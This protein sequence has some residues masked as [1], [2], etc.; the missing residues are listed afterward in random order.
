MPEIKIKQASIQGAS[1]TAEGNPDIPIIKLWHKPANEEKPKKL[2]E[3]VFKDIIQESIIADLPFL[4]SMSF[5]K[6]LNSPLGSLE[7]NFTVPAEKFTKKNLQNF[8][9]INDQLILEFGYYGLNT[10]KHKFVITQIPSFSYSSGWFFELSVSA[11]GLSDFTLSQNTKKIEFPKDL[12]EPTLKEAIAHILSQTFEKNKIEIITDNQEDLSKKLETKNYQGVFGGSNPVESV[13][14]ALLNIGYILVSIDIEGD[15]IKVKTLSK[16]AKTGK[17]IRATITGVSYEI[18]IRETNAILPIANLNITE[19][20][21]QL[22][23]LFYTNKFGSG[24][25]EETLTF[26]SAIEIETILYPYINLLDDVKLEEQT[27]GGIYKVTEITHQIIPNPRTTIELA[28][29]KLVK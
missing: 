8:F 18:K 24:I 7:L 21:N 12:K 13:K 2:S 28:L 29:T 26:L 22:W 16:D 5:R 15:T 4:S 20:L 3:T 17:N 10:V 11:I 25:T 6:G 14:T 9:G 27:L 19:Q 1:N 23:Y